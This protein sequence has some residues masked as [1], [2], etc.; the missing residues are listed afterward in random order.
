MTDTKKIDPLD[1]STYA[2]EYE[3]ADKMIQDGLRRVADQDGNLFCFAE[4]ALLQA[5]M[6]YAN[7][8]GL[9]GPRGLE[10]AMAHIRSDLKEVVEARRR[11]M[12]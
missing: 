3:S 12:T 1:P 8:F 7:T 5:A 4:L 10:A 6:L 9:D 11:R 2:V